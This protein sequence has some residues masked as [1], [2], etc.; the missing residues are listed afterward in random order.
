VSASPDALEARLRRLE[1]VD[2]IRLL[3]EEYARCLDAADYVGYSELFTEDGELHAQLGMAKGR[4]AIRALLDKRLDPGAVPRPT[5]FHWIGNPTIQVDGDRATSVVLWS[6]VTHDDAGFPLVLQVGHYRDELAREDG[7]W[8]FRR[9]E[10]TRDLGYSPLARPE[11]NAARV[12][13]LEDREAIWRLLQDYRHQ[14]DQ[15]DFAAY[16]RLFTEDGEWVG[17]LGSAKGPAEIEA[18]LV[19]TLEVYPD[20]ST[21]TLHLI[22][23]PVI[24]VE[25]DSAT[26]SSMW[27]YLTRDESDNPVVFFV[28]QYEDELVRVES[29]WKFRRRVARRDMPYV[30]V[31]PGQTPVLPGNGR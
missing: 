9:R 2:E 11:E 13:A 30:E 21:R 17:D 15:R 25:G 22:A 20:D 18:L 3:L 4:D 14:L 1:D 8:R 12:R 19:R 24:D 27:C 31:G 23:N 6:Y 5:A 29:E 28:G 7:R 26:A 16:S 10:I